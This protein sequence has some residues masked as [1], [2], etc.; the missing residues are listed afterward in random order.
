MSSTTK[1]PDCASV[2]KSLDAARAVILARLAGI[3]I[4]VKWGAQDG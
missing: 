1:S 3:E 4:R 2:M